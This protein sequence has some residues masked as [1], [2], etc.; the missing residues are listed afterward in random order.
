[1]SGIPASTFSLGRLPARQSSTTL[2]GHSAHLA[3]SWRPTTSHVV[4]PEVGLEVGSFSSSPRARL[5]SDHNRSTK[6][7]R[8][9]ARRRYISSGLSLAPRGSPPELHDAPD[10][11]HDRGYGCVRDGRTCRGRPPSAPVRPIERSPYWRP[12]LDCLV[13]ND[14]SAIPCRGVSLEARGVRLILSPPIVCLQG[15]H[16]GHVR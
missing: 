1:M 11:A 4:A 8:V 2:P 12:N 10:R 13:A 6:R 15:T 9:R 3:V 16:T 14:S 5:L 7:P